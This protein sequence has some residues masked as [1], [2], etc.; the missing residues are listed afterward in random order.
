MSSRRLASSRT[1]DLTPLGTSGQRAFE[2][3]RREAAALGP[4]Y[5]ALFAEPFM[6][7]EGDIIDWYAAGTG[8]AIPLGAAD[9]ERQI[10]GRARLD[11]LIAGIISKADSLSQDA[12]PERRRLGEALRNAVEVPDEASIYLV[13]DQPVLINWAHQANTV[14]ARAG[15]LTTR[16]AAPPQPVLSAAGPRTQIGPAET[17]VDRPSGSRGL[18]WLWWLLWG[19]VGGL[20]AAVAWMLLPACGLSGP[21]WLN[22][23]P[24]PVNAAPPEALRTPDLQAELERLQYD[25]LDRDAQCRAPALAC[26]TPPTDT[27]LLLDVSTSMEFGVRTPPEIDRELAEIAARANAAA[28]G[29]FA[30]PE[31][32]RRYT[33]LISQAK[34]P[35]MGESRMEALRRAL[36]A[37]FELADP[38][39][40]R[41]A[42][43]AACNMLEMSGPLAD[44]T[45]ARGLVDQ[46][47]MQSYTA[48]AYAIGRAATMLEGGRSANDPVNMVVISD[49]FDT[50]GGDPCAAARSAKTAR[51]GLTI[52]V[53][54]LVGLPELRCV[55]QETGGRYVS[56]RGGLE[57]A[58]IAR[59]LSDAAA[60]TRPEICRP[61]GF[62]AVLPRSPANEG[63]ASPGTEEF[64]RRVKEAGGDAGGVLRVTLIWDT[65]SDLDLAVGCPNGEVIMFNRRQACGGMLD[66]DQNAGTPT[67]RPVE[68]IVFSGDAAP[69]RYRIVVRN[70]NPRNAGT[71]PFQVRVDLG[72]RTE[73][74][75]GSLSQRGQMATFQFSFP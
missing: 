2:V 7:P 41:V 52:D 21:A 62:T 70:H 42:P 24:Q 50:C 58:I 17:I 33:E 71:S 35:E 45:A 51:P 54:D 38:F 26:L 8:S 5:E 39:S 14:Q 19:A 40:V 29:T 57:P 67:E 36:G 47:E 64:D 23:C 10:A 12:D 11:E 66:I 31:D 3:I 63:Q 37:A 6:S 16:L 46:L 44:R 15:V 30:T 55:A 48:L 53:V 13:G 49:G 27:A 43:F 32:A 61:E 25:L 1:A 56:A 18:A 69:G 60:R 74:Y 22:W 72:D 4:E 75:R 68:N 9:E 34:S 20:A 28:D 65:P 73:V 59:L